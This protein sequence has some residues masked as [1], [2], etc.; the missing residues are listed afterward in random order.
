VSAGLKALRKDQ[1]LRLQSY[2]HLFY[3]L[4]TNP[5]YL[6]LLSSAHGAMA[7]ADKEASGGKDGKGVGGGASSAAAEAF[8]NDMVGTIFNGGSS[9]REE[10]LLLRY[11]DQANTLALTESAKAQPSFADWRP[12]S[13]LQRTM[14][15]ICTRVLNSSGARV[16]EFLRPALLAFMQVG[17]TAPAT[18][19]PATTP[20]TPVAAASA[21]TPVPS[22]PTATL[23]GAESTI[24]A[25][26][27]APGSG[28]NGA[29][30]G[31]A[32]TGG[33]KDDGVEAW[34]V[35]QV[36]AWLPTA[37]FGAQGDLFRR[38]GVDGAQLLRLDDDQLRGMGLT[39]G[40]TRDELLEAVED[41]GKCT[42]VEE[43][44]VDYLT[45]AYA[46]LLFY[47]LL[48]P[49]HPSSVASSPS[50]QRVSLLRSH[51][52]AVPRLQYPSD[53]P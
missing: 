20:A 21:P 6:T 5:L 37:G 1:R 34:T 23:A 53:P 30:D 42:Q 39:D 22:A 26:P 45:I 25:T 7:A 31:V 19:A 11:Y 48:A 14:Q 51:N 12:S 29:T 18:A 3:L 50:P 27:P 41:L 8:L 46:C 9:A 13:A 2:Q 24:K 52:F 15:D 38:L 43:E 49:L 10:A 32:P 16:V 4:Q 44:P 28:N 40:F 35:D 47:F 33:V 36:L 17:D